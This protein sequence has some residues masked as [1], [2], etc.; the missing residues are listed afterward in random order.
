MQASMG[1]FLSV[2]SEG[3][4]EGDEG[5]IRELQRFCT[6]LLAVEG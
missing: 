3:A 5:F 1:P 2:A 6:G 4:L